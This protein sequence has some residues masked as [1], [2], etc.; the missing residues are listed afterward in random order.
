VKDHLFRKYGTILGTTISPISIFA[1]RYYEKNYGKTLRSIPKNSKILEIGPGSASFTQYLLHKDYEDI[2]VCEIADDNAQALRQFFGDRIRV[3]H[4]DAIDY[5]GSTPD[6]FD[7]IFAAQVIEHFTHDDLI[8]F[9]QNCYASLNDGGYMILETINCANVIYGLYLRYC[10]YSHRMSFTPRSLKQFLNITGSFSS[11]EFIEIQPTGF[12]D[13]LHYI[14]H[15]I[16][17]SKMAMKNQAGIRSNP[18]GIERGPRRLLALILRAPAIRLSGWLSALFMG[19][20]EFDRI[21]VYTPFFAIAAR[22]TCN[23]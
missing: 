12:L 23:G 18:P 5:L 6:R 11:L 20:Y 13:C 19:Y 3:I 4:K 8:I 17:R 10:D 15:R 16:K 21:R 7:L 2:T 14:Y 9:L 22:K 1:L